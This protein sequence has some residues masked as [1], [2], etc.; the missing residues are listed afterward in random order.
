MITLEMMSR[1]E[2]QMDVPFWIGD[3]EFREADLELIRTTVQRFSRLSREEIAATLCEN[4]PWKSPNGRLKVEACHKLLLKLEQ[5][6]VVTLPPLRAQG[7]RGCRE[8][9]G[10]VVQTQL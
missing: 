9:R 1:G 6:G 10:G 4:L 3:R 5:K 7:P 8:R 2:S